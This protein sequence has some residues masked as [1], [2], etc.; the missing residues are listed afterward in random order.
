MQA[1]SHKQPVDLPI[2]SDCLKSAFIEEV[3]NEDLFVPSSGPELISH[4]TV[5]HINIPDFVNSPEPARV[6]EPPL[7]DD[8][9]EDLGASNS[10]D[11][12]S[13]FLGDPNPDSLAK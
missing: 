10:N 1:R 6:P 12:S 9:D 11:D 2:R 7:T 4:T 13:P 3:N 8:L 5:Q